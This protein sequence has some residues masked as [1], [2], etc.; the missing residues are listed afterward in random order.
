[1]VE[2]KRIRKV[3]NDIAERIKEGYKPS[4]IILF[5]SYAYGKPHRDSDIDL[6]VV[7]ETQDRPIDRRVTVRRIV[8]DVRRGFPFS[9]IVVTPKE[10]NRRLEIGDQ[11][12][13]EITTRGEVIYAR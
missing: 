1:M 6:L 5:G 13:K 2:D 9:A 8:S 12:F 4:K 3:I 11:F 10:L 7:K